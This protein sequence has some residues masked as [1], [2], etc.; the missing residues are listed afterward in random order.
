MDQ[1]NS[2]FS[3]VVAFFEGVPNLVT[4]LL[5]VLVG[6]LMLIW[7]YKIFRVWLFLFGAQSG[8]ALGRLIVEKA[9]IG[10]TLAYAL[11]AL[12]IVAIS[13]L[14]WVSLRFSFAVAGF[15]LGAWL[16]WHYG[17]RFIPDF[18]LWF[19]LIG[20]VA[21]AVLAYLFVRL[22]IIIGTSVYGAFLLT[23]GI[24]ALITKAKAGSYLGLASVGESTLSLV[25]T[26][27]TL[28]FIVMGC[29]YQF[30]TSKKGKNIKVAD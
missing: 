16:I 7:G 5:S 13:V 30:N 21:G 24:F 8:L 10:G 23:D 20:A 11:I 27:L 19:V 6:A 18:S 1:L 12:M 15:A 29:L 3:D 28:L 25:M 9:H 4:L 2:I 17:S 14:F 26:L 22:F